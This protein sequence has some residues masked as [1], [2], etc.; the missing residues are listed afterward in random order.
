M[1][2]AFTRVNRRFRL[3]TYSI[4][5][6]RDMSIGNV[7]EFL[8]ISNKQMHLSRFGQQPIRPAADEKNGPRVR[9]YYNDKTFVLISATTKMSSIPYA[10]AYMAQDSI[11]DEMSTPRHRWRMSRPRQPSSHLIPAA[12]R[13]RCPGPAVDDEEHFH[14]WSDNLTIRNHSR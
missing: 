9:V 1:P 3:P 13:I 14:S 10:S 12:Q 8:H 11:Y 7:D 6:F 5:G 4:A 2:Y